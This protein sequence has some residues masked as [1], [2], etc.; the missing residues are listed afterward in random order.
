M[1]LRH[2]ILSLSIML[3]HFASAYAQ[4][5]IAQGSY[6]EIGS[7]WTPYGPT[8]LGP[9]DIGPAGINQTWTIPEHN[10]EPG[11]VRTLINPGTSPFSNSFP[12]ATHTYFSGTGIIGSYQYLQID[13]SGAYILGTASNSFSQPLIIQYNPDGLL[14]PFP[15][16]YDSAWTYVATYS[17][18]PIPGTTV[19]T[20]DSMIY[21]IDGWGVL[22][23][24]FGSFEVLRIASHDF[25]TGISVTPPNPPTTSQF[26]TFTY[27]WITINGSFVARITSD[28][29]ETNSNFAEGS[30]AFSIP[31]NQS[32]DPIRGPVASNFVVGQNYPN[33]FNPTTTLPI[34]L[35]KP[36]HVEITIYNELGERI[37]HEE[38]TLNP[39]TNAVPF[40]GNQW[41]SGNY[42]AEVKAESQIETKRMTLI[43]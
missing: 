14:I 9:V 10:L 12:S 28:T 37:S 22:A 38:L 33:P 25:H 35:D 29:D 40:D 8:E 2:L 32:A 43:K 31:N 1:F 42:F 11:T 18:T 3:L 15:A 24:Q 41:A 17:Q 34:T 36:S 27:K 21:H 23:T 39:G 16:A 6:A 7:S 26:T 4:I 13:D 30:I 20:T 19:T 5:T